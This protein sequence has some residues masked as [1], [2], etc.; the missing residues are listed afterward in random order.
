MTAPPAQARSATP[1][2]ILIAEDSP[3]QARRLMHI[4]QQRGY[5]ASAATN[6][7]EALD[8]AERLHPALIISDVVMPEIDGYSLTRLIKGRPD[9]AAIPVILVTTMSDPQDVIR[10]LEC[11]ADCFILKPYDEEHLIGRIQ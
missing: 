1:V 9:L 7:R 8:M 5:Q 3:T 6:G 4:L 11:G 10:G 2:H